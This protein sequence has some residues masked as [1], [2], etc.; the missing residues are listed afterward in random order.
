[1]HSEWDTKVGTNGGIG[2]S[3]GRIEGAVGGSTLRGCAVGVMVGITLHQR[4][5]SWRIP[6]FTVNNV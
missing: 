6:L 3:V 1:M 4:T 5:V 2:D